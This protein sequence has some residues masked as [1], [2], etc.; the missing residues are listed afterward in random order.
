MGNSSYHRDGIVGKLHELMTSGL[1]RFCS[2]LFTLICPGFIKRRGSQLVDYFLYR[3]N[4]ILQ[5]VYLIL[6]LGGSYLF[7]LDTYQYLDGYYAPSYHKFTSVLA[8]I[9]TLTSFVV[10]S[11]TD[12][13]YITSEEGHSFIQYQYDR[14]LYVKKQCETCGIAKPSRSKHCRVCDKC[15]ARFD[16]HCPWINNCVGERNL[17]YFL[18]FVGNT[19][20]LCFYGFYLCLCA[21]LTIVET[22]NLFKLGYTQGGKWAPLPTSLI[23]RY[24]F[25]ESRSIFPLGIF[26]LVISLFLLYFL[27]YHLYLVAKNK[28]TNETF[29]WSDIKEQ[30]DLNRVKEKQERMEAKSSGKSQ[31]QSEHDHH[32]QQQQQQQQ[33]LDEKSLNKRAARKKQNQ[34]K[35][36][37]MS[38]STIP[39]PLP[40]TAKELKNTFNRGFLSNFREVLFPEA[41]AK[42]STSSS[43]EQHL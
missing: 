6:V 36:L 39:L 33:Q 38:D 17:R 7:M 24:L 40:S 11:V 13:G 21:L 31:Q 23:I 15:V 14:L 32:Q 2:K 26:C 5:S 28:T 37:R 4:R 30:I 8:I 19:S 25:A 41:F 1:E 20:A 12:P 27:C 18:W 9:I 42:E 16:H 10:A 35:Y 22:K 3:P 29:K 43:S 34:E